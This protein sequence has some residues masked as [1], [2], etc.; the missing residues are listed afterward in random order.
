MNRRVIGCFLLIL[1]AASGTVLAQSFSGD[2][3]KIAMGGI[4][5]SDNLTAKMIEDERAYTSIVIPIGL[6]QL[7]ADYDRF[8][9]NNKDKFDPILA[10]EYVANP[11]HFVF[12]RDPGGS[13]GRFVS[14]II[15]GKFSVSRDLNEYRGFAMTNHLFSE[16]LVN[17]SWGKTIK[18]F[19]RDNGSFQG[20]YVGVGPYLSAKTDLNIAK[21]L[22]DILSS[23]TPVYLANQSF[24]IQ[25]ATTGQLAL[26][27]TVG[28]RGRIALPGRKD[29][30][31]SKRDGIYVGMNYHYLK[32]FAY[33]NP[34]VS[35]RFD[36]GPDGKITLNPLTSPLAI[37]HRYSHSGSGLALDF[38]MGVVVK[39]WEFGFGAN[40]AGNRIDW[41]DLIRNQTTMASLFAGGQLID[42]RLPIAPTLRVELPVEYSWNAGYSKKAWSAAAEI[43]NGF[44]GN[45]FHGGVEYRLSVIEFRGGMRYGLDRWHPSGGVGLNLGKRFSIDAAIFGSTTNIERE[46]LP[47]LALSL[48]FNRAEP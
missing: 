46:L 6:F 27:V 10:M 15:N 41:D 47:A 4:G 20:F 25:D 26:D 44:Q 40:G 19:K 1:L 43:S 36:T 33:E 5:Y 38:G 23:P 7:L 17:P 35:V 30:D 28:Y 9:P 37:D 3:R 45:S 34:D 16:G 32:G 18:L 24:T 31:R 29:A 12:D 2:A 48:R 21:N 8:N 39:G 22:T 13:R 14:D 42:Q 11:L